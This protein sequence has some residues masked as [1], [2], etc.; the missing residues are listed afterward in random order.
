MLE[1]ASTLCAWAAEGA[2]VAVA[3]LVAVEGSAPFPVGAA[4][5]L[6][7]RGRVAGGV[8]AGCVEADLLAACDD[9]LAG[10]SAHVRTYGPGDGVVAP[11]VT[12]G[13]T[14]TVLVSP[15]DALDGP[16]WHQLQR[17]A[18]GQDA[19]L[20]L[21]ATGTSCTGPSCG[22]DPL[23][24]LRRRRPAS[25]VVVGAGEVAVALCALASRAGLDVT[26]VDHRARFATK[27]RFPDA[28]AVVVQRA[29][30]WAAGH[31]WSAD[32]ALAVM[33]HDHDRDAAVLASALAAGVGYVGAL[34]SQRTAARRRDALRGLGLDEGL[35]ERLRSPIG[36]D[37]GSSMPEHV[38]VAILAE[39]V[40]A[41]SRA[42]DVS[43]P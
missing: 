18:A 31:A 21:D 41:R 8:S 40:A 6:D 12:C 38:A 11:A 7:D 29:D 33:S 26:V 35:V 36:L 37:L 19:V 9:V 23:V 30:R 1:I 43:V 16:A 17:A 15:L 3:T 32:D 2:R 27:E 10:G 22:A 13:G 42:A 24:T 20:S 39:L 14:V 25:L 34:G 28:H 5:A 4:L